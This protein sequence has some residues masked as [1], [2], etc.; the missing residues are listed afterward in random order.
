MERNPIL[1]VL[2]D[3][4]GTS[5]ELDMALKG[6]HEPIELRNVVA[7]EQLHSSHGIRITTKSNT[8]WLDA[9]HVSAMWQARVDID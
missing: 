9:S 5:A 6:D 2:N 4:V 7:V 1:A 3:M 8:I